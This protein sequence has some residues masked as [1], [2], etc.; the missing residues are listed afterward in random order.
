MSELK[1]G[2]VVKIKDT[3]RFYFKCSIS[4]PVDTEGTITLTDGITSMPIRVEWINGYSN[5]YGHDDLE[6]VNS[7]DWKVKVIELYQE[8]KSL[9]EISNTFP[10]VNYFTISTHLRR[11]ATIK[12]KGMID[13][14]PRPI[15][16]LPSTKLPTI[17][18]IGDTQCKQ[19]IDLDYLHWVGSYIARKKPDIIVHIGDHYDMASLSTYDKGQL[20][21]EGRRVRADIDAGNEG[22]KIIQDHIESVS[23][24]NPRKIVTL[25]NHEERIDRFVSTHPE[26]E[27][28]LGTDKLAFS[29]YGWEVYPFL[30][31]ANVCGINFVHYV[32]NGMTGKPLGGTVLT[33]LKNV[34]ESFVMGHQQVLDTALRYLPLTGKPQI[35]VIVGACYLHDE[36]YKGFQGNHHFR[37]CVMLYECQDGYAMTKPVSL[38]HM[39]ELYEASL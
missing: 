25:G 11:H 26:F 17:F 38:K 30:K 10:D 32:Q 28:F 22:L 7:V 5:S 16:K 24:Y 19:G 8:G 27:G 39:R 14:K 29:T 33:R 13:P 34:G 18:V 6:L 15:P 37:G 23:G 1:V 35:G 21:A 12:T 31:P 9:K 2:D 36:G 20:S 4:N 3:S